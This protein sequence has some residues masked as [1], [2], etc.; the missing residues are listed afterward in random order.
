MEKTIIFTMLARSCSKRNV[1]RKEGIPKNVV[2][3]TGKHL[4]QHLFLERGAV[5]T[6]NAIAPPV[7]Q[8]LSICSNINKL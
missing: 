6:D 7:S 8:I 5:L 1:L 2:K 4:Q 3:F